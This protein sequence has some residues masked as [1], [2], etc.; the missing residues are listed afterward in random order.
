MEPK[1]QK[2]GKAPAEVSGAE[3]YHKPELYVY[4]DIT[5]LTKNAADVGMF[6]NITMKT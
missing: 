1:P 2:Q 5:A 4:G 6:D 3:P